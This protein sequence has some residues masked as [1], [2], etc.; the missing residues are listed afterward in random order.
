M[1]I[2]ELVPV[3]L[4][5]GSGTRLW[6]VSSPDRPKQFHA[7]T[8]AHSL[9]QQTVARAGQ[10]TS[11]APIVVTSVRHSLL[12]L[13]QLEEIGITPARLLVEPCA[14]NTAPAIAL[15][16]EYLH[17]VNASATMWVLP[18]DHLIG[19]VARPAAAAAAAE[20]AARLG[21]LV[22]FGVT[23][24]APHTGYGYIKSAEVLAARDD[25]L[26]VD[27]FLEKPDRARAEAFL[28]D[29]GYYWNSGMFVFTAADIRTEMQR[30]APSVAQPVAAAWQG[31]RDAG[32]T[33]LPDAEDFAK[34]DS[35]SIDYAVMERTE[36]AAV[37]PL[38]AA[39]SDIGSW[40]TIWEVQD[41]DGSE[42][43]LMSRTVSVESQR[44]YVSA[45]KPVALVGV[46][47]LVV[48]ETDDAILIANR[49]RSE[50]VKKAAEAMRNQS[51]RDR[52]PGA[53]TCSGG[54]S[55]ARASTV[56]RERVMR[57]LEEDGAG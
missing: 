16:A 24:T 20:A 2:S 32:G 5:G 3:I 19:D 4:C 8:G 22:T 12:V 21:H 36:R 11:A 51:E 31:R 50:D 54:G 1:P 14:R 23:P 44:C 37:V 53:R 25:V 40:A 43:A 26:A 27:A 10:I 52:A 29:G 39:W 35:I 42:N 41:K 38:D 6:P 28:A 55:A 15:A 49:G 18:S 34:A 46:D 9:L 56:D 30:H 48:V 47:D 33:V 57:L 17:E 45:S 7:L 13:S